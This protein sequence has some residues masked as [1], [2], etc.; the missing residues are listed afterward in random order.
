MR[1]AKSARECRD[2]S[3][4]QPRYPLSS[5]DDNFG[6]YDRLLL[7][8]VARVDLTRTPERGGAR[9]KIFDFSPIFAYFPR[10]FGPAL[11]RWP[12][13]PLLTSGNLTRPLGRHPPNRVRNLTRPP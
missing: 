2:P 5:N 8:V 13:T 10:F 3:K 12:L 7:F 1:R 4:L 9:L 6:V 11:P